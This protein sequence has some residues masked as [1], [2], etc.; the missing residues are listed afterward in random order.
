MHKLLTA[1][2]G[3]NQEQVP[4]HKDR[5]LVWSTLRNNGIFQD[6]PH[7]KIPPIEG[8]SKGYTMTAFR[9]CYG[10]YEFLVM[11]FGLTNAPAA[12]THLMNLVFWLYLEYLVIIFL[13]TS[14][15]TPRTMKS[16]WGLQTLRENKLYENF[17]KCKFWLD[18]VTFFSH[19]LSKD[20]MFIE[21]KKVE[22]VVSWLRAMNVT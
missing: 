15:S 6:W 11:P 18:R 21:P 4:P 10:H 1:E 16:I 9:T 7:V 22:E 20:G 12:F 17:G 14:W 19:L 3:D 2:Q 5:R 8:T 13:M